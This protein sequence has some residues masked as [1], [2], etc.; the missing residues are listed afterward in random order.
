MCCFTALPGV[1]EEHS[2]QSA[3]ATERVPH[4]SQPGPQPVAPSLDCA[5]SR[6]RPHSAVPLLVVVVP[7][8]LHR[9][10]E[11][12]PFP[13]GRLLLQN[14]HRHD[15]RGNGLSWIRYRICGSTYCALCSASRSSPYLRCAY[16]DN[17]CWLASWHD[18]WWMMMVMEMEMM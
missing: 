3:E 8:A 13:G 17:K 4:P 5:A 2:R 9:E 10:L 18:G 16:R 7:V 6:V 14:R 15:W 12:H 1:G 11:P